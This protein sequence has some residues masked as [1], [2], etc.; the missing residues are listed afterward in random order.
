MPVQYRLSINSSLIRADHAAFASRV[1][2]HPTTMLACT[3]SARPALTF[4]PLPIIVQ[5]PWRRA[6]DRLSPLDLGSAGPRP[7]G[8]RGG[9]PDADWP[10]SAARTPP[11]AASARRASPA[12]RPRG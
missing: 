12:P 2:G 3:Q 11:T 6:A 9:G 7:Q 5:S 1:H 8:P 4:D 10:A